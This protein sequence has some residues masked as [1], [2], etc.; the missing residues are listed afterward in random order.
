[1]SAEPK[2]RARGTKTGA[3]KAPEAQAGPPTELDLL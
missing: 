1:M 3:A 2:G